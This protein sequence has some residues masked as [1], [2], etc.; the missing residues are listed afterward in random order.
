MAAVKLTLEM[1][2]VAYPETNSGFEP[3]TLSSVSQVVDV[4]FDNSN[5]GGF[6][7]S[8]A[9]SISDCRPAF[10]H[11]L[12]HLETYFSGKTPT[13]PA[14]TVNLGNAQF[15]SLV[16]MLDAGRLT[17]KQMRITPES[18]ERVREI[19]IV[20]KHNPKSDD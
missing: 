11:L 3:Q 16:N 17:V 19:I 20:V 4:E 2:V 15:R 7:D 12:A 9:A 1:R 13:M 18:P 6:G 10:T 5:P 14:N 8:V